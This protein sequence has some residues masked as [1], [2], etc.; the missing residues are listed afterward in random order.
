MRGHDHHARSRAAISELGL[1]DAMDFNELVAFVEE[2]RQTRIHFEETPELNGM[3]VCGVWT[4][5]GRGNDYIYLPADAKVEVKLFTCCHEFGH[6]LGE[7]LHPETGP[8]TLPEIEEFLA[9]VINPER[10]VAYAY[11]RSTFNDEKEAAAESLGDQLALRILRARRRG[12]ARGFRFE[13]VF[14]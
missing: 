2:R 13:R 1:P 9:G 3:K 8:G 7:P 5:D 10:R 14:S 12:Q 6:M 11:A 4:G